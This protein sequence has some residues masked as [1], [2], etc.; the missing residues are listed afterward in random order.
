MDTKQITVTYIL[1][2]EQAE[3][4]EQITETW[5]ST[6]TGSTPTTPEEL[7]KFM[8]GLGSRHTINEK[9]DFFEEYAKRTAERKG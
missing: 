4:L 9:M 8:M 3:R 6:R 1:T 5:N 2:E 7:F